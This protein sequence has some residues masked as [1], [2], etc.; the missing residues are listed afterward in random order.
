VSAVRKEDRERN[1]R[2]QEIHVEIF[3]FAKLGGPLA[4]RISLAE[5][6]SIRRNGS[7]CVMARGA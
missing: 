5:G 3:V 2:Q 6:H 4:K 1:Y 7:A